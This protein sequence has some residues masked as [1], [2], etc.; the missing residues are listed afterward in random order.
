[1]A[2]NAAIAASAISTNSTC[3]KLATA[4][5]TKATLNA[6]AIAAFTRV[7]EMNHS[8]GSD[9]LIPSPRVRPHHAR[10]RICCRYAASPTVLAAVGRLA[11]SGRVVANVVR[12]AGRSRVD[13]ETGCRLF[14]AELWH[15]DLEELDD[16]DHHQRSEEDAVPAE[17]Y[18]AEQVGEHDQRQVE[19]LPR[20]VRADVG[21]DDV[22]ER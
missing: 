2:T 20:E 6:H 3:R 14:A 11:T 16:D 19:H 22:V 21:P 8:S 12:L 9:R 17:Q 13:V 4:T 5:T 7:S 10:Y 1:M 15:D 18:R